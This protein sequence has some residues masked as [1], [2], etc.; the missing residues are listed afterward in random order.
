M[1]TGL[2]GCE[3]N[4]ITARRKDKRPGPFPISIGILALQSIGERNRTS[5]AGQL[6]GMVLCKKHKVGLERINQR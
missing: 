6:A 1:T 5:A 3:V 2:T 4:H